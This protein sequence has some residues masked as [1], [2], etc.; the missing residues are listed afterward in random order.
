[1]NK[2]DFLEIGT[3]DFDTLIEKANN[4][5]VGI[6]IEPLKIYLDKLPNKNNCKKI[7]CAISNTEGFIDIYYVHPEKIT[8]LSLPFWVKGCN[9]VNK[10]HPTVISH[11]NEM[12][13]DYRSIISKD[14]VEV[15]QIRSI[16]EENNICTIDTLKLDTEGH[17]STILNNYLDYCKDHPSLLANTIIFETNSLTAKEVINADID[18]LLDLGY[19]LVYQDDD[20]VVTKCIFTDVVDK[21]Y[22]SG[23]FPHFNPNELPY[24]NTLD[25]AQKWCVENGGGGVTYQYGRYEVRRDKVPRFSY[26]DFTVK[27]WISL[28]YI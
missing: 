8:E 10:Y 26:N 9:S 6:S 17:D 18:R 20:T 14:T 12:D 19:Y 4:N 28:I 25:A 22:L 15:K 2:L 23:Y 16:L 27:S 13:L 24:E 5:T 21:V 1:M 7:N 11:L 3:S